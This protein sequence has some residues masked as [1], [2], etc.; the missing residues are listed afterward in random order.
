MLGQFDVSSHSVAV[1]AKSRLQTQHDAVVLLHF[2]D[3]LL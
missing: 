2:V 1:A 3:E